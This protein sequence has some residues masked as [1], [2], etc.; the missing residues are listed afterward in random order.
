MIQMEALIQMQQRSTMT[1][2]IQTVMVT[3]TTT[4]MA[5]GKIQ[6]STV[7][8]IVMMKTTQSLQEPLKLG[9]TALI[10]TVMA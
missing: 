4:K 1:V 9:T 10:K 8:P 6:V 2:S 7:E 3:M 5:M